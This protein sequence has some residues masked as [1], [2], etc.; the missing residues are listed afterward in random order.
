MTRMTEILFRELHMAMEHVQLSLMND[1]ELLA[2]LC[3]SLTA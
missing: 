1:R 2:D 3:P